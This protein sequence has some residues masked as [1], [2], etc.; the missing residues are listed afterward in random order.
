VRF[1]FPSSLTAYAGAPHSRTRLAFHGS[2]AVAF[3]AVGATLLVWP[4]W[5]AADGSREA[6]ELQRERE[7]YLSERL[8][9]VRAMNE[10]LRE[11]KT[12]GRRIFLPGEV[13]RYPLLVRAVARQHG[14]FV[15]RVQVTNRPSARWRPLMVTTDPWLDEDVDPYGDSYLPAEATAGGVQSRSVLLVMTGS[16]N[17]VYKTVASLSQ[18]QQLFIP[19]RWELAPYNAPGAEG[20]QVRAAIWATVF[21]AREPK[22]R[23]SIAPGSPVA[24]N[25]LLEEPLTETDR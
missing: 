13:K 4:Q 22:E 9:L 7:Q 17:S 23:P 8:D 20:K 21:V 18:Q 16:W 11:W 12:E 10:R 25:R 3:L 19:E 14:T 1:P 15:A 2:L 24:S 5:L 6:L